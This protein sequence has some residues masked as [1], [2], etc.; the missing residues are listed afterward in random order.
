[1]VKVVMAEHRTLAAFEEIGLAFEQVAEQVSSAFIFDAEL[2]S[3]PQC[4]EEVV[5]CRVPDAPWCPERIEFAGSYRPTVGV[6]W[7]FALVDAVTR[8]LSNEAAA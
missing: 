2:R 6:E 3:V 8:D 4:G 7:E 5:A 1:M